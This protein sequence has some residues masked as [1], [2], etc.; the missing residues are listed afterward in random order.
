MSEL[1]LGL[2]PELRHGV[3]PSLI[4]ANHILSL[5]LVELEREIATEALAN[6]AL[7][8]DERTLACPLCGKPL[9]GGACAACAAGRPAPPPIEARWEDEIEPRA[10]AGSPADADFD[11]VALVADETSLADR[12]LP[13]AAATLP[14]EDRPVA[15]HL[16]H[17]LDERG[18]LA[19]PL[20]ELAAAAGRP[21]AEVE[22]ILRA[23]QAAA[24]PG[25]AARDAREC[26]L[27]QL[28]HLRQQGVDAPDEVRRIV[29]DHL[30]DLAAHRYNAIARRLGVGKATVEAAR[31]YIRAHL[32][33]YPLPAL[34][35]LQRQQPSRTLYA[36]PD[37]IIVERDGDLAVEM[38]EPRAA[39][40][41]VSPLYARLA[42][43]AA[44]SGRAF[45][46]EERAHLRQCLSQARLFI[47]KIRQRRETLRRLTECLVELQGDFVREG[48]HALRPLTRAMV[49]AH[50]GVHESTISRAV[51]GKHLMLPNRRVVPYGVFFKASLSV[52]EA[53]RALIVGESAALTDKEIAERLRADGYRV[54]RRTIAK[55]RA[56]LRILPSTLR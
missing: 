29:A 21:L 40:L 24:P 32:T 7:E 48:V 47:A 6:P 43:E 39:S 31:E 56:E 23:V 12:V 15:E 8:L 54:A 52:K 13:D 35:P 19:A 5:P 44:R 42:A 26:L 20:D 33:P 22:R 11:P 4:E 16:L 30:G 36:A 51:A 18:Y 2:Q 27:L 14:T 53:I 50:L 1:S 9:E 49:A 45:S 10:V 34:E 55:Y 46:E 3:N 41:R 28:A 17:S 25:V 37:A 38:V